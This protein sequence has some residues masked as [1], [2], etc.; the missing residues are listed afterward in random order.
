M[1][2]HSLAILFGVAALLG[3]GAERL[4]AG[5][6]V[7]G[8]TQQDLENAIA[9]GGNV[10]FNQDCQITLTNPIRFTLATQL[11]ASGHNVTIRSLFTAIVVSVTNV[12]AFTNV[13]STNLVTC[14][15]NFPCFTNLVDGT[16]NCI[17]NITCATN[18]ISGT[19]VTFLTNIFSTLTFSNGVRLFEVASNASVSF[20]GL[21]FDSGR[22][23]N[24]GA[25][26]VGTNAFAYVTNCVFTNNHAIGSNGVTGANGASGY[27]GQNGGNG[28]SGQA[29]RG[30]AICNFGNLTV[31]RSSFQANRA[32]GGDGGAGGNGGNGE[33][34][35]GDGGI[36]GSGGTGVGGAI[37]GS[38]PVVLRDCGFEGNAAN[39]GNG[40]RGGTN[41]TGFFLS[42]KGN[43]GAGAAGSG[44][45]LYAAQSASVVNCTF[46]DNIA[47]G[48]NSAAGGLNSNGNGSDGL[49]GGDSYGGGMGN[50]GSGAALTN[51]TFSGNQVRGGAGGKGGD[52]GFATG[53]GGDG[54][55]ARGGGLYNAG[56]VDV[57][58]CTF[59]N[60]SATGGT[61]GLAGTGTFPASNGQLGKSR[62]G[63]VANFGSRFW[64]KN[65]IIG[66][67]F[68]AGG[69]G[70]LTD[71][72]KNIS[73][74]NSL[75]F[76][77]NSST[78]TNPKLGALA[79][80]GGPTR[81]MLLLAGSPAIN[82]GDDTVAP[83]FDQRGFARPEGIHSDIGAVETRSPSILTAPAS[84]TKSAGSSVTFN[85][86][87]TGDALVYQ[88]RFNG[89][90]L[91]SAT[92]TAYTINNLTTDHAGNYQ[93]VVTNGFGA[94]T[95]AP[96]VLRVLVSPT[97]AGVSGSQTNFGFSYATALGATYVVEYKN[98]L[99]DV[100]WTPLATNAG[101]GGLLNY[102]EL[103]GDATSRFYRVVVR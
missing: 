62:G 55:E 103:T 34:D 94:V 15:T 50:I 31:V 16:I 17:T 46:A 41:G 25:I 57:V 28:G 42:R 91:G 24:G 92:Q 47:T 65:S 59:A 61:N 63:N 69:Y 48:G 73:A 82:A 29:G 56:S 8:C 43:G 2:R 22:G 81:T 26:L 4:H 90:E 51:C 93:V 88:W 96:A 13:T 74:D 32:Y 52:G 1:L 85:V 58:N 9:G 53:N 40:G 45:G 84:Q 83:G 14:L 27:N 95:S 6:V 72:G 23:T 86:T 75:T 35:G 3:C 19:N 44:A 38:G 100:S 39:G 78:N 49:R 79:D 77:I 20:T 7:N 80:N 99:S 98:S 67:G 97:L 10:T 71:A 5:G 33:S 11:D 87:A 89:N 68:P 64:L 36:G 102:V 70:T 30:G 66:T 101:T 21:R 60:G 37:Y 12:S 76:G 18:V 54:G